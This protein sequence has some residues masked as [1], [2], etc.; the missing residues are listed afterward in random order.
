[1]DFSQILDKYRTE[2]FSERDKGNKFELL[3]LRYLKTDPTYAGT[4]ENVWLWND[5]FAKDQFG[6]KDV[7][8]D[9][10]AETSGG[11]FW[12]IQCKCYKADTKIDKP[13]VDT[14]LATSVK[15]F[16]DREGKKVRFAFRL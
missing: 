5:F 16:Q 7:G 6:G 4:L 12:A 2:S 3:M 15:T 13:A 11:D 8:I 14:F 10:V 9:L 1:M